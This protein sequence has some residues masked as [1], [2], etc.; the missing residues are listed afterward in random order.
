M[1]ETSGAALCR[2]SYHS[3]TG[4]LSAVMPPPDPQLQA[5]PLSLE[6]ADDDVQVQPA[7]GEVSPRAP[8]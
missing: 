3:R 1:A 6:G 4:T 2:H 5:V 7:A 8:V